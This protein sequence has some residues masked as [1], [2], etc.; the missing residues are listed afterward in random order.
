MAGRKD[1]I[2]ALFT[3]TRTRIIIL[4]TF[5]LLLI[6]VLIGI[7][8]FSSHQ[9]NL[10]SATVS[11][12]PAIRSIP[13]SVDP[14]VEY[15][16]LQSTQNKE[17][18]AQASKSG[19]SAIPTI[20]RTQTFGN[21]VTSVGPQQGQG[22]VGF[23]TLAMQS[24]E[25][26]E[27][28]LWLQSL[29]DKNCS[30]QS[31]D[32]V[33]SQGATLADLKGACTCLQLKDNGYLLS[34]L[35][36]ICSCPDLKKAGFNARQFKEAGWNVA[37]LR[38]CGFDACSLKAAG[39]NAQ[40][41]KDGGFSDGEL[42]GAG[43]TDAEIKQASGLPDGITANDVRNAGCS[44][45]GLK[46]LRAAGVSATAIRN[47]SGCSAEQLKAA[48]YTAGE[49]KDAGFSA[50]ELKK[51]GFSP[52]DLKNAG[53][54]ARD[55]LNAGFT[56]DQLAAAG[57]SN[58]DI[59]AAEEV[60]PPGV[61]P[62]AVKKAGC[63]AATLKRE[64]LA[65]ISA[66]AI[67]KYAGCSAEALK[68][69]GFS[70]A[71]LANAGFSP[72]DI[73]ALKSKGSEVSDD[74]IKA[75]G[76]DPLKLKTLF[77]SGVSAERIRKINGC[78]AADLKAAGYSAKDLA[79]AGFS[80]E[81]LIAAGF[82]PKEVDALK[83]N[84]VGD[85]TI[86]SAGCDPTKL[87]ALLT[88]G[89]SAARIRQI[90]GCSAA[91]L[92]A[93]GFSAKDLADAGFTPQE[94][95][96][97][98]FKPEEL[99]AI[100]LNPTGVVAAGRTSDCSVESLKAAKA[101]GVSAKTIKETLGCSAQAMKAAGFSAKELKDAGYTAAELKNAGFSA[102]DLKNAGFSAADLKNAGFS[103]DDLK[104]AGFS[105]K[106]LKDAGVIKPETNVIALTPIVLPE[107][108]P[109]TLPEVPPLPGIGAQPLKEA[110]STQQLQDILKKQEA[111]IGDQRYQQ[112]IQQKMGQMLGVANQLVGVW[113]TVSVQVYTGGSE[114]ADSPVG[115]AVD[116]VNV[117]QRSLAD[118]ENPGPG[119]Q[120]VTKAI[121]K[122]GDILFAVLDSTVNSDEPSPIL[123][124]IVSGR[125]RGAKLIGSFTLPPNSDKM[126]I[127]FNTMSVQSAPKAT[128]ISAYAIDANTARTALS[129]YA[130]HHY[131]SRYG[132]LFASTFIE[133]FG[134]AF[135]SANTTITIGGTGEAT[136]TTIESGAGRSLLENAVIGLATLGKSW[137]QVAQVQ[138]NRPTTV[139]VCAGTPIGVLFTQDL[140][141]V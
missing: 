106:D 81:E 91:A 14:T 141:T 38:E 22:A 16:E 31:V 111:I 126:V 137:G 9:D 55:L 8:R 1:N 108:K 127:S 46:K 120:P 82:D 27:K 103:P 4:F 119:A 52:E 33:V 135:Q 133:G 85:D 105:D 13:G 45:E 95:M 19:G 65:G 49:L 54:S 60:L 34:D 89:V 86:R 63:D 40:E 90:N 128:A 70:D 112:K 139:E 67:H 41:L 47:I 101:M 42:K 97:A 2:K 123:A 57:Y 74:T 17:Q 124:T 61:T 23:S 53:F 122:T 109:S 64:R 25:G 116:A 102:A 83:G 115:A 138:F 51:A 75:A 131:I 43:F 134:N 26:S 71:D 94:L 5:I 98:G 136:N 107:K 140:L 15:E 56:P 32:D 129:S 29:K 100:G 110:D 77:N 130:N 20:I 113:K 80:P 11:N 35:G 93:A 121:V 44:I 7:F 79:N 72:E 132:S 12:A 21:G 36:K 117:Q 69:A 96:A 76:C 28:S 87:K 10:S 118:P 84:L 58:Q 39:F 62:D 114:P 104:K 66:A 59:K 18:A 30:K 6:A 125:F 68:D 3:N 48:G 73:A 92:K 99:N 37:S 88:A 50:A 24:N 78:S